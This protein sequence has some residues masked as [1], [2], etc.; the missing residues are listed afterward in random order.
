MSRL[1]VCLLVVGLQVVGALVV[2]LVVCLPAARD[3]ATELLPLGRRLGH[4]DRA[5]DSG[6]WG[7]RHLL[8][9]VLDAPPVHGCAGCTEDVQW[10]LGQVHS[11][12]RESSWNWNNSRS[13]HDVT[14]IED[15][16][17]STTQELS[18]NA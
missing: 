4:G 2:V 14:L 7:G 8:L 16:F 3:L 10:S 11:L 17:E 18:K 6:L 12:P 5:G 1:L 13:T 9:A 15:A